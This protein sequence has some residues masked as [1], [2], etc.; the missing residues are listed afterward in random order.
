[1]NFNVELSLY[2]LLS[3]FPVSGLTS[4]LLYVGCFRRRVN[5]ILDLRNRESGGA[6]PKI[7]RLFAF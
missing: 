4:L 1:M 2:N 3:V 6:A 5:L 7:F